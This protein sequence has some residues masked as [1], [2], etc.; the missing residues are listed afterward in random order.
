MSK[1]YLYLVLLFL[2]V[3]VVAVWAQTVTCGGGGD[4]TTLA[5]AINSFKSG[6]SNESNPDPNV[7]NCLDAAYDEQLPQINVQLTINGISTRSTIL[8]QQASQ[9][10]G[11]D[12][13]AIN[14][15]ASTQLDLNDL[16]LLPSTTSPASDDLIDIVGLDG[17]I[18]NFT[19]CII[20]SNYSGA[21]A[22][23]DGLTAPVGTATARCG[24]NGIN[25]SNALNTGLTV[26][27]S[28]TIIVDAA[29]APGSGT[30]DNILFTGA[31]AKTLNITDG[32]IVSYAARLNIQANGGTLNVIGTHDKPIYI[33]KGLDATYGHGIGVW[34][35]NV[36]A[37][38]LTYCII[39]DNTMNGVTIQSD[40]K[41]VTMNHVIIANNGDVGLAV[42]H[43]TPAS[44]DTV[45]TAE[46]TT[47]S[48][49]GIGLVS[50]ATKD[51]VAIPDAM[52]SV[53]SFIGCIFASG[54]NA[55]NIA[56]NSTASAAYSAIVLEGPN[57]LGAAKIG[58]GTLVE[59]N[60]INSDPQFSETSDYLSSGYFDVYNSAFGG[61]YH[62]SPLSGGGDY[63]GVMPLAVDQHWTLYW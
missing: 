53:S 52:V 3:P 48:G 10:D 14:L 36:A 1:R 56:V 7:I 28:K 23:M 49:N 59:T 47:I 26:N 35:T 32:S 61:A 4:F 42:I 22:S 19:N 45:I 44:W 20:S 6:G 13:L 46:N 12:G 62:G 40:V 43:V 34:T 5:A 55:F 9:G 30:P 2:A 63:M 38:N 11:N 29:G 39:A 21:P 57:A 8:L 27:V 18:I 15:P 41:T 25:V 24:D 60:V 51:Q 16:I 33:I 58:D 37:A 50:P 54:D 31:V 17:S